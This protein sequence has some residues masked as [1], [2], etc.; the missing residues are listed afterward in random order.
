HESFAVYKP[1][2]KQH[3]SYVMVVD[4]LYKIP[5][6]T[7]L[8]ETIM[9]ENKQQNLA[10]KINDFA[11]YIQTP[12]LRF[13]AYSK[14]LKQL[15]HYTNQAH[16]DFNSLTNVLKKFK[17]LESEWIKKVHDCQSHLMVFE[18]YRSI[19]NCPINVNPQRR[20][21]L[22]AHLIRVDL[23]DITSTS[24]IRMYFL[25][26][27][28]LIYCKKKQKESKKDP[29][30]KKLVYK[31]TLSLRGAEI[32]QLAPAFCAKMCEEKK[33]LFRLGKKNHSDS[34]SLPG[35]EAFGFELVATELNLD[36][37]SPLHQNYMS[38]SASSGAPIKR[39]HVMRTRSKEEQATWYDTIRK[40]IAYTNAQPA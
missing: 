26:N 12:L 7:K 11:H 40:A 28:N 38:A 6:F 21:L 34:N 22:F 15:N 37:M 25:Y 39:R 27:D 4:T 18:A 16:P 24:D 1:F 23:D 33:S 30:D 35:T 31:G 20:L 32:R 9:A 2:M 10:V 29:A 36:A 13:T 8:L 5:A 19:Q 17:A 3:N 14:A